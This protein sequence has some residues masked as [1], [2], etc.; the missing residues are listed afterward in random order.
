MRNPGAL[1]VAA[2]VDLDAL[3]VVHG[4]LAEHLHVGLAVRV[5]H[6]RSALL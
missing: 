1:C 5:D 2:L 4:V 3:L 6:L